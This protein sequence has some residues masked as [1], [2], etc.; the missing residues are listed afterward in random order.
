MLVVSPR[1]GDG[2]GGGGRERTHHRGQENAGAF[3]VGLL[4]RRHSSGGDTAFA[5][6]CVCRMKGSGELPSRLELQ[7]RV[8]RSAPLPPKKKLPQECLPSACLAL[9]LPSSCVSHGVARVQMKQQGHCSFH[10][11]FAPSPADPSSAPV[12]VSPF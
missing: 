12:A 10:F 4:Q 1:R 9:R 8:A 7:Y 11:F 6:V 3:S 2:W 5:G